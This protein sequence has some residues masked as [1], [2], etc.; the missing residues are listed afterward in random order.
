[1]SSN[2][3]HN[4]N[5]N[6]PSPRHIFKILAKKPKKNINKPILSRNN[7]EYQIPSN[8]PI[9][10]RSARL[11]AK[12]PKRCI[13]KLRR[14]E[15]KSTM[16]TAKSKSFIYPNDFDI[17][18]E[19]EEDLNI[20]TINKGSEK[21]YEVQKIYNSRWNP[22]IAKYDYLAH[23]KDYGIKDRSY[24]EHT[25]GCKKSVADYYILGWLNKVIENHEDRQFLLRHAPPDENITIVYPDNKL[26]TNDIENALRKYDPE[27]TEDEEEG[28]KVEVKTQLK[29]VEKMNDN[30]RERSD[31]E[32]DSDIEILSNK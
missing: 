32:S 12:R 14:G 19:R 18:A 2:N 29:N 20:N 25:D 27:A 16:I 7:C 6:K 23:W 21:K 10:R 15:I 11:A 17:D 4:K 3:N 22:R 13:L 30:K 1:M 8:S 5:K 9:L 26:S 31:D 24:T 28:C